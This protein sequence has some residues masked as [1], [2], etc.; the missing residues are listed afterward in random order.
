MH[1]QRNALRPR[2][3]VLLVARTASPVAHRRGLCLAALSPWVRQG[4]PVKG[5]GGVVGW[6]ATARHPYAG[7]CPATAVPPR[8][9]PGRTAPTPACPASLHHEARQGTPGSGIPANPNGGHRG[10]GGRGAGRTHRQPFQGGGGEQPQPRST[11][12]T[13]RAHTPGK[14]PVASCA[15]SAPH[16]HS[17]ADP[18]EDPPPIGSRGVC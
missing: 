5:Q 8:H 4:G 16:Q 14:D 2:R 9:G 17:R 15:R 1:V 18:W 3:Q 11:G 7:S 10:A 13:G 12:E 6:A